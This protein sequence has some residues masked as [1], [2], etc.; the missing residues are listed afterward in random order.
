MIKMHYGHFKRLKK[1][2]VL[3]KKNF[4]MNKLSLKKIKKEIITYLWRKDYSEILWQFHI[5]APK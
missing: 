4:D 1:D 2:N 5:G 3:K